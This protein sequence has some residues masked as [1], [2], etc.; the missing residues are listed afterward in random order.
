MTRGYCGIGIYGAKNSINMGTLWRSAMIF[1]AAFIFT[2]GQ[3]Y[4]RQPSDT[5]K[6]PN[7]VPLYTWQSFDDFY[8]FLPYDA[9]IVGVELADDAVDIKN[10]KHPQRAVYVLGAEDVG[11]PKSIIDRCHDVV[12]L[13]GSRS[14]NVATA[15]SIVLYDRLQ[16][17]GA[18]ARQ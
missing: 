18:E 11:L 10:Y 1:D 4:K 2:I 8:R 14:L 5:Y 15:G 12:R 17:H 16:R 13:P 3:R 7:H 6:T 9:R